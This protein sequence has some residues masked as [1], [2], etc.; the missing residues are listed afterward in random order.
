MSDPADLKRWLEGSPLALP[1]R[2]ILERLALSAREIQAIRKEG[3]WAPHESDGKALLEVGGRV[4]AEGK[5]VQSRKGSFFKV[6]RLI[7]G[8][9]G[10]KP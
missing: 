9:N 4:L 1:G 8:N 7:D 2:V 3:H 6:T 5:I 10:G